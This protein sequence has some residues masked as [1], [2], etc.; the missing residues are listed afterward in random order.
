MGAPLEDAF[1]VAM[2]DIYH[3]AKRECNYNATYFHRMVQERGGI[4][5][6]KQL[7][8][9]GPDDFA[10]GFTELYMCGRLDISVE[11]LVLQPEWRNLFTPDER[12]TSWKRLRKLDPNMELPE[13]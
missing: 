7:L 4:G 9:T 2:L 8:S 5:A 10:Q 1:D 3:R 6:A 12:L 11:Y 13:P